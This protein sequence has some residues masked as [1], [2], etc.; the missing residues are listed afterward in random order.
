MKDLL[1]TKGY[2]IKET[3]VIVGSC[4]RQMS[5]KAYKKLCEKSG[6]IS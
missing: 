4:L 6:L 1:K 3:M 5:P 2:D